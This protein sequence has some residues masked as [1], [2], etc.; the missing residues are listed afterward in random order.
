MAFKVVN[1]G[2]PVLSEES[3]QKSKVTLL[4]PFCHFKTKCEI[5]YLVKHKLTYPV[6]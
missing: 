6:T 2:K 4:I 1:Y 3:S 5:L